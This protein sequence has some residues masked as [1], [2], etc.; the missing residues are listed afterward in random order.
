MKE[1]IAFFAILVLAII[2]FL[3]KLKKFRNAKEPNPF[4]IPDEIKKQYNRITVPFEKIRIRGR[5]YFEDKQVATLDD[6][7]IS[8]IETLDGF[9]SK[10]SEKIHKEVSIMTYE[11]KNNG[12]SFLLKS[13]PFYISEVSLKYKL[14]QQGLVNIFFDL[15][16]K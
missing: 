1:V 15:A 14:K 2:T 8:P 3:I 13:Y 5:G 7:Y 11:I 9:T 16:K 6:L 12:K 4:F 10:V